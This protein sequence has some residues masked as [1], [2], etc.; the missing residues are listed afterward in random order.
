MKSALVQLLQNNTH[1]IAFS[2]VPLVSFAF[3]GGKWLKLP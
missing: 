3:S 1:T 2:K